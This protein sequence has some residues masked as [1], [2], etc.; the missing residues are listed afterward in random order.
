MRTKRNRLSALVL[1]L[2]LLLGVMAVP[3]AA[4]DH[5]LVTTA[6]TGTDAA[7]A[8]SDIAYTD[9]L[10][11]YFAA[12]PDELTR[13]RAEAEDISAEMGFDSADEMLEEF[14]VTEMEF[15]ADWIDDSAL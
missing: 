15:F 8:A 1:A 10:A 11:A 4:S 13:L 6:L 14:G 3:A 5:V 2:A 12:N 9:W 7:A